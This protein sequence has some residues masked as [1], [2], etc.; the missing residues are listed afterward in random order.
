MTKSL[1]TVDAKH[2]FIDIVEYTFN[3]SVEAQSDLIN[4]LNSFVNQTI[5]LFKIKPEDKLYIPTGDGMCITLINNGSQLDIHIKIALE[6]LRR[7]NEHNSQVKDNM[8]K[9]NIRVGINENID[10]LI[11]DIN[12]N[13]N[14]SGLGINMASRIEGLCDP[15]QIL[16]GGAVYEKLVQREKYMKSFV[17]YNIEIKHGQSIK[18]YQL[19]NSKL[20]HLNSKAPSQLK[21]PSNDNKQILYLSQIQAFYLAQCLKNE[22]FIDKYIGEGHYNHVLQ[23]LLMQLAEDSLS[24]SKITKMYPSPIIQVFREI[25]EQYKYLLEVDIYITYSLNNYTIDEHLHSINMLFSEQYLYVN[26]KGVK[27]LKDDFPEIYASFV[28]NKQQL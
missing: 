13:K 27:M 26:Q 25:T 28:L 9:F 14:I 7:I 1:T 4:Y 6:I 15:G 21:M 17:E 18:V 24:K 5:D 12:N 19:I 10:N 8:R 22:A 11:T 2:I 16:V 20:K 3:R 23:V